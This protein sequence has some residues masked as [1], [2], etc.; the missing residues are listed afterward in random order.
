MPESCK[1]VLEKTPESPSGEYY[2]KVGNEF[3]LV[4]CE[5]GLNG[6][7]YTFLHPTSLDTIKDDDLQKIFTDKTNFLL[8]TQRTDGR[9]TVSVLA[10]L[11][12]YKYV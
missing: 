4:Y 1:S 2:I 3:V 7:G 8:R 5:M 11:A 9:Q 6:G 10:Q 12:H